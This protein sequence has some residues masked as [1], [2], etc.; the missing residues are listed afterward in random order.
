MNASIRLQAMQAG[1]EVSKT[2]DWS[3]LDNFLATLPAAEQQEAR[4]IFFT[5]LKS[6]N[7]AIGQARAKARNVFH[8]EYRRQCARL[9][10]DVTDW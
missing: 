1:R 7:A 6:Q 10:Y 2:R 8:A 5:A 3:I 9:G 4:R